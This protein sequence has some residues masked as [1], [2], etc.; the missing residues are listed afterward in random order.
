MVKCADAV[1]QITLAD[2]LVKTATAAGTGGTTLAAYSE[3][4]PPSV[5]AVTPAPGAPQAGELPPE[6][7]S[8]RR[9]PDPSNS[10]AD[11]IRLTPDATVQGPNARARSGN[12]LPKEDEPDGALPGGGT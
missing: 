8:I 1:P 5:T 3:M 6:P 7:R 12:S 2:L 9:E 4:A 10:S 11:Q